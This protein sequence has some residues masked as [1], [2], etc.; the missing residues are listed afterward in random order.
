M[1]LDDDNIWP[2]LSRTAEQAGIVVNDDDDLA[3][4]RAL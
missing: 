2:L 1:I 3:W 4:Q